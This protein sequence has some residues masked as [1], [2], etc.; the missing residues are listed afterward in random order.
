MVRLSGTSVNALIRAGTHTFQKVCEKTHK[1]FE[2]TDGMNLPKFFS[3]F[4]LEKQTN[5]SIILQSTYV[6]SLKLVLTDAVFTTFY[7]L[8]M[9]VAW[10]SHT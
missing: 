4:Q 2:L 8:R 1:R 5:D 3:G 6:N 10:S 9:K 7:F